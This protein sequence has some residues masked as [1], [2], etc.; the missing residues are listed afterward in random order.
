MKV[1]FLTQV[2]KTIETNHNIT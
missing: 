1:M 2:I